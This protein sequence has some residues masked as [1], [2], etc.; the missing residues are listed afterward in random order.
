MFIANS[1]QEEA[2]ILRQVLDL[3]LRI[4]RHSPPMKPFIRFSKQSDYLYQKHKYVNKKHLFWDF[5]DSLQ[6]VLL[7]ILKALATPEEIALLCVDQWKINLEQFAER[8][9]A[10]L[11]LL[12]EAGEKPESRYTARDEFVFSQVKPGSRLLYIGCGAG[13]ECLRFAERGYRV[14][15]IDTAFKLVS[16]AKEWAQYFGSSFH[17]ICMDV[18]SLGLAAKSFEGLLLEFYGFQPSL[19]QVLSLQQGLAH[20]LSDS[21]KGIIV[22]YRKGYASSWHRMRSGYPVPMRRWL[23]PQSQLDFCFSEHDRFEERLEY[24][25]YKRS[26][27]KESLS[28]ELSYA[29]DVQEC[30]YEEHD[31]RYVI[32][33]V[34]PKERANPAV[35]ADEHFSHYNAD[36]AF[37]DTKATHIREVLDGLEAICQILKSHEDKVVQYYNDAESSSERSPLAT[38]QTD[39]PRLIELLEHIFEV[40]LAEAA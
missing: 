14:I 20:V 7:G 16:V 23:I 29:F 33:V 26:H 2:E 31:S 32:C 4:S 18:V 36:N 27:T 24:G 34:K 30:N 37:L 21:G 6:R 19:T 28:L 11:N 10:R 17:P 12:I 13:T 40:L 1:A 38:V 39:L 3:S 8:S 5:D 35:L 25:L 9:R 22:A 15:G